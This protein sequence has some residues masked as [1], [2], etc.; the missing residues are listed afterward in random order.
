MICAVDISLNQ[1]LSDTDFVEKAYRFIE[2]RI[3]N[4]GIED[5]TKIEDL[6]NNAEAFYKAYLEDQAET[7]LDNSLP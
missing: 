4:Q 6:E 5:P 7:Q 1:H 3:H 2:D